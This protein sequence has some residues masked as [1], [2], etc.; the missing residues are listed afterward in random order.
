[1]ITAAYLKKYATHITG[2][3]AVFQAWTFH[4]W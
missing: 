1:M 3:T 4:I 2:I